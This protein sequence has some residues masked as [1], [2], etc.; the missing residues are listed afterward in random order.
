MTATTPAGTSAARAIGYMVASVGLFAV[1]NALIKQVAAGYP[2][3][4]IIFS[5]SLFAFI[6]VLVALLWWSSLASLRTSRPLGHA[7]RSLAGFL[8]MIFHFSA[9]SLLPLATAVAISFFTPLLATALAGPL[10][11]ERV[12]LDRWLAIL[13]GFAGVVVI[14]QPGPAGLSGGALLALAGALSGAFAVIFVRRLGRTE[15]SLTIVVYYS[16]TTLTLSSLVLPFEFVVPG[17]RDGAI[18]IAIGLVGGIAQ[19]LMTWAYRSAPMSTVAPFD[20]TALLWGL[21]LGL[22]FWGEMPDLG[23]LI[24]AAVIAASGLYILYRSR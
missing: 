23:M 11:K 17:W 15:E 20:Y 22:L 16:L 21:V 14:V 24:G 13:A 9:L 18:F 4:Q 7:L 12:G 19:I 10:L 1:M 5:R 8:A 3:S 2:V 6:P